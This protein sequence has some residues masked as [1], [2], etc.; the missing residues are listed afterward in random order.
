[1]PVQR[2]TDAPRTQAAAAAPTLTITLPG[3]VSWSRPRRAGVVVRYPAA[4]AQDRDAWAMVVAASVRARGWQTPPAR[5]GVRYAVTV[6]VYGGGKRDLDRVCSAVLDALQAGGGVRDDCLVDTLRATRHAPP[7]GEAPV[8]E[9]AVTLIPAT[10]RP[11]HRQRVPA[12][13]RPAMAR[14]GGVLP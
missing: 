4:Y 10:R 1:M 9:V 14:K 8:T 7:R 5:Q 2:A 6:T 3:V 11:R 12:R 13:R